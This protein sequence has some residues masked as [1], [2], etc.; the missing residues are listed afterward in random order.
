MKKLI[1]AIPFLLMSLPV[2]AL[3]DEAPAVAPP[4]DADPTGLIAFAVVFV[5]L[6]GVYAY[7]IWKSEKKKKDQVK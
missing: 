2:L 5:G 4:V 3:D 1:S 6:I 7:I